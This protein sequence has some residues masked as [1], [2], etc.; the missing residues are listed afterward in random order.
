[1]GRSVHH[2]VGLIYTSSESYGG[3]TLFTTN[4]GDH[5]TLL[6]VDGNASTDVVHAYVQ[7]TADL[8]TVGS[9]K[10]IINCKNYKFKYL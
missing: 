9:G 8:D 6:D 10:N 5:A 2:P 3:Y 4:G 7:C 1:M